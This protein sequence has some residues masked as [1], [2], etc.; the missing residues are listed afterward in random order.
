MST[1]DPK[2]ETEIEAAVFRRLV[3]HFRAHTDLQ[4]IDLMIHAGFCRNCLGDWFAEAAAE[5]GLKLAK[6]EARARV[7][8]MPQAVWKAKFQKDAT[9]AQL[10]AFAEAQKKQSS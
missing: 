3:E 9:P 2:L 7:Y 6:D 8:G 5:R 4:N 1:I 10:K